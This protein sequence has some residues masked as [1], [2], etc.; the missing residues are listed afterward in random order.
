[1]FHKSYV[2]IAFWFNELK[3]WLFGLIFCL[4]YDFVLF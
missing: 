3:A 1:M 4:F 2:N